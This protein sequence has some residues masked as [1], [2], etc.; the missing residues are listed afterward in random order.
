MENR[1]YYIGKYNDNSGQWYVAWQGEQGEWHD[2]GF[3]TK[4]QAEEWLHYGFE[5]KK[6]DV[7]YKDN[8]IA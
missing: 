6:L 3:D 7:T 8:L 4:K 1:K 5:G 2:A